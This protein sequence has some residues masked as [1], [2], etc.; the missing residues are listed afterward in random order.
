M[1]KETDMYGPIKFFLETHGYEVKSEVKDCD[2]V[3]YRKNDP[4]IIIELK[5]NLTFELI[6]QGIKRLSITENVYIAVPMENKISKNSIWRRRRREIIGMCRRIGI[7]LI[8]VNLGSG[9]VHILTTPSPYKPKKIKKS[10]INLF[11]EFKERIGDPNCGGSHQTKIIT[12]YRQNAI[13]CALALIS[14]GQLSPKEIKEQTSIPSAGSILQKNYYGWFKKV[15][16][17]VYS[18][19]DLGRERIR[20]FPNTIKLIENKKMSDSL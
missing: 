15:K 6:F 7:G 16:R 8:Q 2:V 14:S 12:V 19:S 10:Q 11:N 17:G 5:K 9:D 18:L 13:K 3:G 4:P 1:H 20:D